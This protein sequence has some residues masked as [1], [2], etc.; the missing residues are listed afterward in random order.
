[1]ALLWISHGRARARVA[2]KS[3]LTDAPSFDPEL[4]HAIHISREALVLKY[5]GGDEREA[6][7]TQRAQELAGWI[8]EATASGLEGY[9]ANTNPSEA[10]Q[11]H[12]GISRTCWK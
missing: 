12:V 9:L 10:E 3:W 11:R 6:G 8:V 1:M 7:I 2:L 4:G 5:R